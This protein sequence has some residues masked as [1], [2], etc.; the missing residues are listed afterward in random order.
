VAAAASGANE[1]TIQTELSSFARSDPRSFKQAKRQ[2]DDCAKSMPGYWSDRLKRIMDAVASDR[3]VQ[4]PAPEMAET[5]EREEWLAGLEPG[6][7]F[8]WLCRESPE[9]RDLDARV[10][11][12]SPFPPEATHRETFKPF[13]R[14][15]REIS[16]AVG[17][18]SA[19]T[20]SLLRSMTAEEKVSAELLPRLGLWDPP[21]PGE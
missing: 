9:L 3:P 18:H 10:A 17:P 5:Y 21:E 20:D 2:A 15:T 11:A 6:Q 7:A 14:W 19:A 16:R 1:E 8:A 4:P 13:L 12:T